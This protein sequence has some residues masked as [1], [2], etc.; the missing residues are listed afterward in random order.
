MRAPRRK[1]LITA[2]IECDDWRSVSGALKQL[3][4]EIAINGELPSTSVSGGYSSGWI[5]VSDVDGD[6]SHDQWA[7]DL[8]AWLEAKAAKAGE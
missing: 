4:T 6:M 7:R 5:V 8:N 2:K 3:L 1:I